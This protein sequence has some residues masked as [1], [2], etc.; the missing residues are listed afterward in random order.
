MSW[1]K[2]F[3]EG[4]K[5]G[6]PIGLGYLPVSFTFGF[7]E[8]SGGLPVWVAVFISLTN[9]TSAGQFAGTILILAGAGYF[10]VALTTFVINLRYMLMSL[11]LSQK[12]DEKTGTGARLALAFGIT[13]ETFVVSSLHSGILKASYMLGLITMPILGWN[14]GTWLGGAISAVLPQALQNAMG[15][16]LYAMFIALIL[17]AARKSR[18]VHGN[19]RMIRTVKKP[20]RTRVRKRGQNDEYSSRGSRSSRNTRY[21]IRADLCPFDG[22]GYIYSACSSSYDFPET[23][24]FE[25]YPIF[26]RLYAVCSAGGTDISGCIYLHRTSL[27]GGRRNDRSGDFGI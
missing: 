4:L 26:L 27:F 16:A 8:V 19:S 15:I 20:A 3:Y 14:L 21:E 24:P 18:S 25:V 5:S 12:L 9:L 13:D 10:E 6:I 1:K 17:P 7:L 2:T 11:S 23:D 22:T